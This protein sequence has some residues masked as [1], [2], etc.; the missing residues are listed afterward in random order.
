MQENAQK[1]NMTDDKLGVGGVC[2]CVCVCAERG[3]G[4]GTVKMS[5]I[6]QQVN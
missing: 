2:V 6:S 1:H 4:G 3:E 5:P